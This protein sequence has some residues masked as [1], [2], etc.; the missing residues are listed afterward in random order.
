M[1]DTL[2]RTIGRID[3]RTENMQ[4]DIAEVKGNITKLFDKCDE[5]SQRLAMLETTIS[6]NHGLNKRQTAGIGGAAG[7]IAGL[8]MAIIKWLTEH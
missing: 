5:H 1:N 2:E 4:R 8:V 7:F 3:E 6:N